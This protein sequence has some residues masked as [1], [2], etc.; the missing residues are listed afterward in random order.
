MNHAGRMGQAD[1]ESG[2]AV[3]G[4]VAYG[5]SD[6]E[7]EIG[8]QLPAS[9]TAEPGAPHRK[10]DRC[11]TPRRRGCFGSLV[12]R[13]TCIRAVVSPARVSGCCRVWYIDREGQ[14]QPASVVSVDD[15]V[16]PPSYGVRLDGTG[17]V[18][19]TE[20]HRLEACDS[21]KPAPRR[22]LIGPQRSRSRTP[23]RPA[24]N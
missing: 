23:P 24:Y 2:A 6:S 20:G 10:G 19:E 8:P 1:S 12:S 14:R 4:L 17:T 11:G 13:A 15:S 18:R 21:D 3:G 7:E 5:D 16:Q 9:Q 22:G